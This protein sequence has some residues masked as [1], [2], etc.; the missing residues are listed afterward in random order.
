MELAELK[1]FLT[2]AAERS[3]SRAAAKLYRTQPAISQAVRRLEDQLGER[4]FD[5]KTKHATLTEAG[6]VLF[7]EGT[8]L[9]RVAEETRAAVRRRSERGRAILRIGGSEVAAHV[10][11]PSMSSFLRQHE[12]ISVEFHRVPESQVLVQVEAGTF[13]IGVVTNERV[14]T[15]FQQLQVPVLATGFSALVPRTHPL[16]SRQDVSISAFHDERVIVL[17]DA[18]LSER[19]AAAFTEASTEPASLMGMPGIDSLKR[20]VEMGLGVGLVPSSVA[21]ALSLHRSLV[22]VPLASASSL[23]SMTLIY[24]R[25]EPLSRN[26]A[27]F[28]EIVRRSQ[29][30]PVTY[31][32]RS[33]VRRTAARI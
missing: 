3:F 12:G 8:R 19:L 13:D 7:R 2:V 16:A 10:V 33:S 9:L 20:A 24:C 28:L 29:Q 31:G 18:D 30:S 4:L 32:D 25:N 6:V 5:R 11:L 1:V 14:P 15:Q 22:A 23:N 26:T 27:E 21:S 17:T